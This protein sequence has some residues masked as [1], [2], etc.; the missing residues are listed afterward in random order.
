MFLS[1]NGLFIFPQE[2]QQECWLPL[3][4]KVGDTWVGK[5]S[6][7]YRYQRNHD[8]LKD[9]RE[10]EMMWKTRKIEG[11]RY[12]FD[13]EILS[14]RWNYF[15]KRKSLENFETESGKPNFQLVFKTESAEVSY[16]KGKP[17]KPYVQA[18]ELK[19]W[20][21]NQVHYLLE[22]QYEVVLDFPNDSFAKIQKKHD[23]RPGNESAQWI[24]GEKERPIDHGFPPNSFLS[25]LFITP[26]LS[27]EK[28]KTK[29]WV[30]TPEDLGLIWK[31]DNINIEALRPKKQEVFIKSSSSAPGSLTLQAEAGF[32]LREQK[33]VDLSKVFDRREGTVAFQSIASGAENIRFNVGFGDNSKLSNSYNYN[34]SVSWDWK[35]QGQSEQVGVYA[36]K[37]EQILKMTR[38]KGKATSPK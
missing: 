29:K 37:I 17:L 34:L 20:L 15:A 36:V 30:A 31:D 22:S 11:S 28:L 35:R 1:V 2:N 32:N 9:K 4:C 13:V 18:G 38:E 12:I 8:V 26:A 33:D 19:Q 10:V 25:A 16:Q 7:S 27:K 21:T 5:W 14:A 23:I 3:T 6:F 24:L